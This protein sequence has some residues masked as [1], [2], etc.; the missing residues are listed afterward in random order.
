MMA[1]S[2]PGF[3]FSTVVREGLCETEA[4]DEREG[5]SWPDRCFGEELSNINEEYNCP[6]NVWRC[7]CPAM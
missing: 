5:G 7:V 6:R 1:K 3:W 4:V 2:I